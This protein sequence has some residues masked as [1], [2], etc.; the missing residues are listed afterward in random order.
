MGD[1]PPEDALV[2]CPACGQSLPCDQTREYDR[3]GDR[4][5]REE[6][7]FEYVCKP[8]HREMCHFPR[9]GLEDLLCDAGSDHE[10]PQAFVRAFYREQDRW[11][12]PR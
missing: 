2:T 7:T 12:R 4:W 3:F 5:D 1:R 6:K 9:G 11:N 8:C 10:T